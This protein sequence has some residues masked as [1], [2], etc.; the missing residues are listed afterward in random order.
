[1]TFP[2]TP[3]AMSDDNILDSILKK[4]ATIKRLVDWRSC[5]F[6]VLTLKCE[7]TNTAVV[8]MV[9]NCQLRK[10][11][12][13]WTLKDVMDTI[14]CRYYRVTNVKVLCIMLTTAV[15]K[16]RTQFMYIA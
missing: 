4:N 15:S 14:G 11:C 13:L 5:F 6:L 8:K 3:K 7:D 16:I 9:R 12:F 1:M 10:S 2:N